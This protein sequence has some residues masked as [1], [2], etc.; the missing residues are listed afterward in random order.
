M[1]VTDLDSWIDESIRVAKER[2]YIPTTFIG[3]RN[4]HGTKE[5]MRRL[6]LSGDIQSGFRKLRKLGLIEWS[7]EA[8]VCRFPDDFPNKEVRDAAAW[9]LEQARS[10]TH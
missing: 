5:A 8:G 7:V 4:R 3:M 2:G 6:V 10:E 1:N 9:R